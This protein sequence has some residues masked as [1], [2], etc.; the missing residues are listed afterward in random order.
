[1]Y[2]GQYTKIPRAFCWDLPPRCCW[3]LFFWGCTRLVSGCV[4]WA[5]NTELHTPASWKVGSRAL[6]S[7]TVP[8]C[9][10]ESNCSWG[11]PRSQ[12]LDQIPFHLTMAGKLL[13]GIS[14]SDLGFRSSFPSRCTY[15]R[16]DYA[17]GP[18]WRQY[19]LSSGFLDGQTKQ[20]TAQLW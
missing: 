6:P 12:N 16:A 19:R 17:L 1:M 7:L 8:P 4:P 15:I 14:T 18:Q 20:I 5:P 10:K 13:I 9:G 11:T 3:F 2:V